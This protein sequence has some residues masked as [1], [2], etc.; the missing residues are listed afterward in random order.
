MNDERMTNPLR[1]SRLAR[2]LSQAELAVRAGVGLTT[3]RRL[4][5]GDPVA[6]PVASKLAKALGASP[7]ERLEWREHAISRRAERLVSTIEPPP[8]LAALLAA[9]YAREREAAP[10]PAEFA[11][12]PGGLS[13]EADEPSNVEETRS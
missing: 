12:V 8:R 10:E 5:A 3:V 1:A 6:A 11:A 7:E 13:A 9:K 4:E 2:G